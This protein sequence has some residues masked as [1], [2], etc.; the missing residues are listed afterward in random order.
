MRPLRTSGHLC[1]A[2]HGQGR[3]GRTVRRPPG[4]RSLRT[5][6]QAHWEGSSAPGGSLRSG[7][8]TAVLLPKPLSLM[9]LSIQEEPPSILADSSPA[10]F[11]L[12]PSQ[13]QQENHRT[14]RT[15]H[16]ALTAKPHT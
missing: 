5:T 14:H 9:T 16:F 8:G 1:V 2:P 4:G 11:L 10:P 3:A 7:L 15:L 6:H 12:T 13:Q